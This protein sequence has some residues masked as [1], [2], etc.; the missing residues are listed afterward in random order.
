MTRAS[1]AGLARSHLFT[2]SRLLPLFSY[3]NQT[4][5]IKVPD[6]LDKFGPFLGL[7]V[8]EG[9]A[10]STRRGKGDTGDSNRWSVIPTRPR[11]AP[12]MEFRLSSLRVVIP[13]RESYER[14][15]I[16]SLG[17]NIP[18]QVWVMTPRKHGRGEYA[19]YTCVADNL[20]ICTWA[21]RRQPL[22]GC[23][24]VASAMKSTPWSLPP[25]PSA[26]NVVPLSGL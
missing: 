15:L 4:K 13:E 21:E 22:C 16:R 8:E 2:P 19:K 6:K 25:F 14:D 11:L 18:D 1:C 10:R 23:R 17:E 7:R 26:L 24:V 5:T 20:F 9:T 3:G 12:C